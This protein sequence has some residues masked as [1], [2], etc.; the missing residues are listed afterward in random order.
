MINI[1]ADSQKITPARPVYSRAFGASVKLFRL[2]LALLLVASP[3]AAE[4]HRDP[5][6]MHQFMKLHPCPDGPDKG[7]TKRCFGWQKDHLWA[8]EC[9]G[10]DTVANL[11][12]KTVYQHYW[13]SR[14]DNAFCKGDRFRMKP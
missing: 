6:V 10:P 3:A 4:I 7:S 5:A 11:E 13:K 2:F 14:V 1:N 8:L 9:G 12:W